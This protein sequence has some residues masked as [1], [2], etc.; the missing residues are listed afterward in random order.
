MKNLKETPVQVILK[1]NRPQI[2]LFFLSIQ[3]KIKLFKSSFIN[4]FK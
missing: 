1:I 2:G 3:S 4:G